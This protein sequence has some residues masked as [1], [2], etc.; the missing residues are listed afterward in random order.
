MFVALGVSQSWRI[1]P[2]WIFS[3]PPVNGRAS[4]QVEPWISGICAI[5]LWIATWSSGLLRIYFGRRPES[6]DPRLNLGELKDE[7]TVLKTLG[8]S[9]DLQ[10]DVA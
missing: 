2:R 4:F 3:S 8:G 10:R 1:P 7:P 6:V 5:V 9:F